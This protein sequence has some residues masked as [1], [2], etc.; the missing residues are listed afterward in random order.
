L[1]PLA[2]NPDA[3]LF[4][5]GVADSAVGEGHFSGDIDGWIDIFGLR[6]TGSLA[7]QTRNNRRHN[8]DCHDH[9]GYRLKPDNGN[10]HSNRVGRFFSSASSVTGR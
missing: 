8:T 2:G 3:L 6:D 7:G 1:L 5:V 4:V 9:S 10:G